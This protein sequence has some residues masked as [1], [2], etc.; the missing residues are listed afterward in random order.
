VR[1]PEP[2]LE[3]D[4]G[5]GAWGVAV[6]RWQWVH[7]KER[8]EAVRMVVVGT[9]QWQYWPCYGNLDVFC[10]LGGHQKMEKCRSVTL[11]QYKD[12]RG[13]NEEWQWQGGSGIIG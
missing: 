4:R 12:T 6:V 9:W 7:S 2:G 10:V 13:F 3:R 11:W 5:V 8:V 1:R